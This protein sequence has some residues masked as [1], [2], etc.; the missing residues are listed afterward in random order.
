MKWLESRYSVLWQEF[1]NK[2]FRIEEA[3]K[4]LKEKFKEGKGQVNVVL[5]EFR[6]EKWL[7][8]ELDPADAR[9]RIYK[10]IENKELLRDPSLL[11]SGPLTRADLEG[12]L[13]RAA[14]LIRTR[15]DYSFILLLLFYKRISDKWHKEFEEAYKEALDD[16]LDEKEA[17]E[18]AQKSMYHDFDIPKKF[19]WENIRKEP[20]KL[21]ENFSRAMK[22]LGENNP[23]LRDAFEN[24]DFIQFANNPENAEILRQLV[25]L[26]SAKPLY[27][28]SPDILGDAYEWILKYFA[29]Q[30]AKE[31][32]VYTPRE[33]IKLIVEILNPK[34]EESVYDPACGSAGMLICS[35]Q[36]I[37]E[38][39]SRDKADKL[40]LSGQEANH[41]TLALAKMNLYI[42]DIRNAQLVLGDTLLYPKF[43]KG[44]GLKKF[45]VV[46]ANPPWNQDGYE[47]EVLKKGEF[48]SDR[49]TYGFIS[50]QSA[51][52][53]WIQHMLFS[54]DG[55]NGRIGVVIDNGALFRGGKEQAIRAG[56][57]NED[58]IESVLL[59]P[60]KLF[61]NTGAPGGIIILNKKKP[62]E[63]KEKILFINSSND[64]EQHPDVRKLNRLGQQHIKKIVDAY[65]EFKEIEGY[66]RAVSLD[67]IKGNDYNLN[68]TLYVFPEEEVEQIN[69]EKE[70]SELKSLESEIQ[71]TES[72]IEGYLKEIK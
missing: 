27:D 7:D 17:E 69:I 64:Y 10:L 6:K 11:N 61:Y 42:H 29:P 68:V 4:V 63:R 65:N 1:K 24:I 5:S 72:K 56:V 55:K 25:E 54:A 45:N 70:W 15:V 21:S 32:E 57:L 43:K 49:F 33:V 13:K 36:H 67:E 60:E 46:I 31:G 66:S 28:V 30:K 58:L 53:A 39:F 3:E 16:G 8:A 20:V 40:F 37:E 51:D 44:N 38:K 47:E 48:V 23:E 62:K 34:P 18:E 12:L 35:Y 19:L 71:A 50:R 22:V 26:F 52:W 41:K 9:K 59:L 2:P 14:D